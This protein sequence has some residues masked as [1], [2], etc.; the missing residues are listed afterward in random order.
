M[1]SDLSPGIGP[2]TSGDTSPPVVLL[3]GA[4]RPAHEVGGKAAGLMSAIVAGFPVPAG[5]VIPADAPDAEID[6]RVALGLAAIGAGPHAVRSSA[7][8][9]DS[10]QHS[11][12][13]QLE[14]RLGVPSAEVAAAVR[15]VRASGLA[16]RALAYGEAGGVAVLVQK[17]VPARAAGVVFSADPRTGRRDVVVIEAVAGLG[18]ALVSGAVTPER[19]CGPADDPQRERGVEAE[20]LDA[21]Q[22]RAIGR[23]VQAL[24]TTFGGP[25]DAEWALDSTGPVLLQARPITALPAH[26]VPIPLVPLE[27]DWERD[28]H[29]AVLSPLGRA[30]FAPYPPAMGRGLQAC[31]IPISG[32]RAAQHAGQLYMQFE[33]GGGGPVPPPWLF[34]IIMWVVSRV[35]PSMRAANRAAAIALQ[36]AAVE[37]TL[38]RWEDEVR[39]EMRRRIDALFV[40]RPGELSDQA[41][42]ARIQEALALTAYGLE[43]HADLGMLPNVAVGNL[44]LFGADELGWP[45]NHAWQLVTG[46][47]TA[48]TALHAELR[49]ALR[50]HLDELG[51]GPVPPNWAALATTAPR[52]AAAARE[53]QRAHRLRVLHYEPRHP[54]LGE[55]PAAVL[56]MVRAVVQELRQPPAARPDPSAALVDEAKRR[57]AAEKLEQFLETLTLAR[58]AYGLR[59]ENGVETVSR[60]SGLLRWFVLEL[61]RRL[62]ALQ[63]PEHAVYLEVS[64]HAPALRGEI[65]DLRARVERR[66][67]EESWAL[68]NRGPVRFG[69]EPPPMPHSVLPHGL[70][71]LFRIF[72][73]MMGG[74]KALPDDES[75][76][77]RDVAVGTRAVTGRVRVIDRPE[78]IADVLPGEVLVCR[79]TS[80]ELSL[81]LGAV[82]AIITEEGGL[83][84]HPAV[85]AREYDIPAVLAVPDA[86]RR[87][88]TGE[89]VRVDPVAG[90][91]T[92]LSG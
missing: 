83:L 81:G 43:Q 68:Q 34:A 11:F 69:A 76:A 74:D 41:L 91:V 10:G 36:P 27:G 26:P 92:R 25:V 61:G 59:D 49:E 39:P 2:A 52:M 50:P 73:W 38:R 64:E 46:R 14:T 47:S 5:F 37:A 72:D 45:M 12:A 7:I 70:S 4:P 21:T 84:S 48:T 35:L 62:P 22:A 17:M 6:G 42:L 56:A 85:I 63:R 20:V 87:L 67:G 55:S 15:A 53:F 29:H 40:E 31:G 90:T 28:D 19:W 89:R 9:E 30:W 86:R 32:V 60:P 8:F 44:A 51:G 80:P 71:R 16:L 13:G 82:A 88:T 54:S 77:L 33:G 57:L 1:N 3:H 65:P 78:E 75:G 66:R 24:A 58:R 18:D 79:I 23:M